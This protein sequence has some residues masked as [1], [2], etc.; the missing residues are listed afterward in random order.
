MY[1]CGEYNRPELATEVLLKMRRMGIQLNAV[2]YGIYHRALMQGEWPSDARLTAIDAW[3]RL[4]M[5][6]Q[7]CT[8]FR[9]HSRIIYQVHNFANSNA[10]SGS[11]DLTANTEGSEMDISARSLQALNI[12]NS[13]NSL[14]SSELDLTKENDEKIDGSLSVTV[15]PLEESKENQEESTASNAENSNL[16]PLGVDSPISLSTEPGNDSSKAF[17]SPS[18]QK[19]IREHSAVP[20]SAET[21]DSNSKDGSRKKSY[22]LG[23]SWFKG[24]A[25]SPIVSKLMRSQTSENL[26]A[27]NRDDASENS[28]LSISPSLSSL[29]HQVR[30]QALKG[31]DEVVLQGNVLL[32]KSGINNLVNEA[33]NL[34]KSYSAKDT[35]GVL[36]TGFGT[37]GDILGSEFWMRESLPES[38]AEMKN[39]W[40]K[41][42]NGAFI[43]VVLCSCSACSS[44]NAV[45][46]DEELMAGWNVDDSNLNSVCPYCNHSF[47]PSL[48]VKI[49]SRRQELSSS[50]YVPLSINISGEGT[51]SSQNLV[52]DNKNDDEFSVPFISPLVLRRELE[53]LLLP[54]PLALSQVSLRISNPVIFWNLLYYCRR[55]DLPTH[56]LTWISPHV[57]IRC[58]YDVPSLHAENESPI[59]FANHHN[60]LCCRSGSLLACPWNCS[61][62]DVVE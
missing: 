52:S 33:I 49:R 27:A 43:D 28:G 60:F 53:S 61:Q 35:S 45:I 7:V 9:E 62:P 26:D 12:S 18:R 41:D 21:A 4:R 32:K 2:T 48:K 22:K 16:D 6:L 14:Y 38:I 55:L 3:S 8:L 15:L 40:I 46:Y 30:K 1:E 17:L 51:G 31:Y 29:V 5:R 44:C 39:L 42:N 54:N 56:I 50:W 13:N 58:V 19:F 23:G 20:F 10:F 37:S 36:S 57:H 34:N 11:M 25:N 59:Y 24:I 47:L